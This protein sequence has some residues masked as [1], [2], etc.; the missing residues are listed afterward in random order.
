M[1]R[2]DNIINKVEQVHRLHLAKDIIL[3]VILEA[4]VLKDHIIINRIMETN[5]IPN[6]NIIKINK[7]IHFMVKMI[8]KDIIIIRL[9]MNNMRNID[10]LDK[11]IINNINKIERRTEKHNQNL[12]KF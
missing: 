4:I 12:K 10:K 11:M 9:D 7:K 8:L 5:N 1:I 2:K 6:N 3:M